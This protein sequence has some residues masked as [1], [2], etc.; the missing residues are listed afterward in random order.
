MRDTLCFVLR[1]RQILERCEFSRYGAAKLDEHVR[2][3]FC[4]LR[5]VPSIVGST[6]GFFGRQVRA[7]D[8][9]LG[10]GD[11]RDLPRHAV[12]LRRTAAAVVSLSIRSRLLSAGLRRGALFVADAGLSL[13]SVWF[14]GS[15]DV[16]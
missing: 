16:A 9:Q 3:S 4:F 10:V 1:R 14:R 2:V 5:S 6:T 13:T 15:V 12:V 8:L 7:H 11:S